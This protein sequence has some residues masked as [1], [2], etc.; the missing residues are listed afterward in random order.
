MSNKK[1]TAKPASITLVPDATG[2]MELTAKVGN[3][4]IAIFSLGMEDGQDL[5]AQKVAIYHLLAE[6][7]KAW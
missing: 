4:R 6:I 3:K 5:A 1:A 7:R 2:G